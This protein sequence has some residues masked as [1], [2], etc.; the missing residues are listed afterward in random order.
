MTVEHVADDVGHPEEANAGEV[1]RAFMMSPAALV[2]TDHQGRTLLA[3]H[4]ARARFENRTVDPSSIASA[5]EARWTGGHV[6]MRPQDQSPPSRVAVRAFKTPF[7][8]LLDFGVAGQP[9]VGDEL[10][11]LR[12]RVRQLERLAA[13]DH[14]T[15]AWNRA[16]FDRLIQSEIARSLE[17]RTPVSLVLLDIDHFKEVND[18]FGHGIGDSVLRDLVQLL[19]HR[20]RAS[21]MLFRWGGEEFAVLATTY[22]RRGAQR[23][24]QNLCDAVAAHEFPVVGRITLSAGVAEHADQETPRAWFTRLDAALYAA[25]SAGR[26]RVVVD[27]MGNSDVWAHLDGS[28]PLHLSWQEA[29]ECGNDTID[30][31]H[32][33]LFEVANQLIDIAGQPRTDLAQFETVFD[34]MLGQVQRHFADEEDILQRYGYLDL[35]RHRQAHAG[36]LRRA[37]HLKEQASAG[38]I[39]FGIVVE[40]LAQDVVARHM[41]AVDR[42]F[43]PLFASSS[44]DFEPVE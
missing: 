28:P 43:F 39:G 40:F 6:L 1:F 41:L 12:A 17:S 33:E 24:A 42:A 2:L 8:I 19:Q 16:H 29:Y 9:T 10:S 27:A 11:Q 21:D 18:R 37:Q 15:G 7:H 35:P 3:N 32:R 36:L 38:S 4:E 31:E 13:T 14:L 5:L 26:N 25:K 34:E 30:R 23:L 22:G 20:I 44:A